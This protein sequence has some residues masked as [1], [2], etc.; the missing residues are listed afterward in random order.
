MATHRVAGWC[1]GAARRFCHV[2]PPP[3]GAPHRHAATRAAATADYRAPG[4]T[5]SCG[6]TQFWAP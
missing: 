1:G 4:S 3:G 6:C 5:R 2:P